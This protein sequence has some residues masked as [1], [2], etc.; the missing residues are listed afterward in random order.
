MWTGPI[1]LRDCGATSSSFSTLKKACIRAGFKIQRSGGE[2]K[3]SHFSWSLSNSRF[4]QAPGLRTLSVQDVDCDSDDDETNDFTILRRQAARELVGSGTRGEEDNVIQAFS[5]PAPV[6]NDTGRADISAWSR[7]QPESPTVAQVTRRRAQR[8]R[9]IAGTRSPQATQVLAQI[10][11][12]PSPRV[13]IP[14]VVQLSPRR[15][16]TSQVTLPPWGPPAPVSNWF[17][18]PQA[19]HASTQ[20]PDTLPVSRLFQPLQSL[21]WARSQV[22]TRRLILPH[23]YAACR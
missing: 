8:P 7:H 17:A 15:S 18:A 22:W 10:P 2:S 20:E 21:Q 4:S 1:S 3:L 16:Q 9:P 5:W 11:L 14:R 23:T 6:R 13:L 19:I 12:T